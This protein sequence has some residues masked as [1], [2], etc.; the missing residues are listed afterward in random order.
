M[1]NGGLQSV[2]ML[3]RRRAFA[4]V[5]GV[6]ALVTGTFV[7]TAPVAAPAESAD[8][9]ENSVDTNAIPSG[10]YEACSENFGYGKVVEIVV[11]VDGAVPTPPLTY[12]TDVNVVAE[13]VND[14][15]AQIC[16]PDVV[17]D[18]LWDSFSPWADFFDIP[19]PVGNYVFLP[20]TGCDSEFTLNLVGSP[21][22]YIV[23]AGTAHVLTPEPGFPLFNACADNEDALP[24]A[25]PL[26]SANAFTA[27]TSFV[28]AGGDAEGCE[29]Q[30]PE[31]SAD[32]AAAASALVGALDPIF[33]AIYEDNSGN[34][35]CNDVAIAYDMFFF[36]TSFEAEVGRH[37]VFELTTPPP[38]PP[39]PVPTAI[40]PTFT[41]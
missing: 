16:E 5:G 35:A 20:D 19:A 24:F 34:G 2:A 9:G 40:T 37:A 14:D 31:P 32:L 13:F 36:Q 15:G 38:P 26:M 1:A 12:P 11:E 27:L 30:E 3:R 29:L 18:A 23:T 41:G 39:P 33:L 4:A 7:A 28:E 22:G 21:P 8:D 6:V 17:T 10:T 25:Q